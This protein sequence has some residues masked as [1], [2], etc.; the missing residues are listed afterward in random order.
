MDIPFSKPRPS[1]AI[2][3]G[4]ERKRIGSGTALPRVCRSGGLVKLGFHQP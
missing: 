3:R 4:H 1:H 2:S